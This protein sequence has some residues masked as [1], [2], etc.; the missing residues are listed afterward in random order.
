MMARRIML[1]MPDASSVAPEA[2]TMATQGALGDSSTAAAAN[3]VGNLSWRHPIPSDGES[4]DKAKSARN[5][6]EGE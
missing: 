6:G 4:G 2:G 5:D 1:A 3:A